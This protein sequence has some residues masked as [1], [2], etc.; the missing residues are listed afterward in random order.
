MR[1]EREGAR[2]ACFS[3]N[4]N[5][6]LFLNGEKMIQIGAVL[7]VRVIYFFRGDNTFMIHAEK[8]Y[9]SDTCL[10]STAKLQFIFETYKI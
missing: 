8:A 9:R 5:E 3:L 4:D 7:H 6:F 2:M 1:C 10:I